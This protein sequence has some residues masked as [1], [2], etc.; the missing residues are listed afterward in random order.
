M[1]VQDV[2]AV[3]LSFLHGAQDGQKFMSIAL[4]GIAL[5]FGSSEPS[6]DGFPLWLM[7]VCSLAISL[8]TAVGGK[9][10][11]KSVA[12]DMVKLEVPQG[13]AASLST[14][15][16]LLIASLT[17]MPVST[18]HAN[19]SS[20]MGVGF[21]KNPHKV[22]WDIAKHMVAAWVLTFPCCGLIGFALAKLFMTIF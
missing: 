18:S 21:I 9:R 2:C 3:A 19:T 4:L 22:K 11:I 12:M 1:A 6:A 10:I 7:I 16:T 17:G 15:I 14:S 20:I 5:S 8:G 13:V